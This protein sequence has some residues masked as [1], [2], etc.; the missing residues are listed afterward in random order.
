M[1]SGKENQLLPAAAFSK[2]GLLNTV[3]GC[4]FKLTK[5]QSL[6]YSNPVFGL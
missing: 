5:F 3:N 4:L 2:D 6:A 1:D